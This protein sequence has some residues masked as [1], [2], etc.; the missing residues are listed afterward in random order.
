MKY[1]LL[2][3]SRFYVTSGPSPIGNCIRAVQ[4]EIDA[5]GNGG[6]ILFADSRPPRDYYLVGCMGTSRSLATLSET[7]LSD[8]V[9]YTAQRAALLKT[10]MPEV[11]GFGFWIDSGRIYWDVVTLHRTIS[12][13]NKV[14]ADRGEKTY[15]FITFDSV[16]IITTV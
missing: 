12:E 14:A 5:G 7:A 4:K 11:V 13:A 6:T 1:R 8:D 3:P 2:S 15:A 16:A 10:L 9:F